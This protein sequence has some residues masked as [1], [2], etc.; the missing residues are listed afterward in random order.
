MVFVGY[1]LFSLLTI[2]IIVENIFEIQN[3]IIGVNRDAFLKLIRYM[4][5]SKKKKLQAV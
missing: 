3:G 2:F 5:F 4:E 1:F